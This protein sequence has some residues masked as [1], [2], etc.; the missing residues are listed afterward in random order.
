MKGLRHEA[1]RMGMPDQWSICVFLT[2]AAVFVHG[3]HPFA[4]DAGIY[5]PA[6]KK[7]LDPTLYPQGSEFFLLPAHW[8]V[9][10]HVLANTA[11]VTHLPLSY[12]LLIWYVACLFFTIVACWKIADICSGSWHSGFIGAS[13]TAVTISMPAAGCSLLLFDPYLTARSFSTPLLLFSIAFVLEHK[14]VAALFCWV[15]AL[16]FHPLMAVIGGLLL[17]LLV[18]SRTAKR[19]LYLAMLVAVGLASA[20]VLSRVM[21]GS[22]T[23]EYRSAVSTRSYFFLSEWKWYELVGA[24]APVAIFFWIA[25]R[26]RKNA[27][28]EKFGLSWAATVLGVVAILGAL[29]IMWIP[30]LFSLARFQPMRGFQL[31]YFLLLVLP[32]N[33]ALQHFTRTWNARPRELVF[34]AILVALG[35]AMYLAQRDTFPASR[36]IE[37]PWSTPRNSWQQAFDWIRTNTPKDAVFALDPDYPDDPGNDRQGFRAG[38]ERSALPDRAKDGGVAALFP[39]VAQKW[40]ASVQLTAAV[41]RL[42][43]DERNQL[44][45]AGVSW[46]LLR[47]E[48]TLRLDCPYSN[49]EVSVCRLI[50]APYSA[51]LKAVPAQS[52]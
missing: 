32:V 20:L 35:S 19:N 24:L 34:G 30:S 10:T 16:F 36:H 50:P 46:V 28:S 38:A 17:V 3:Y 7:L 23:G 49:R 40:K 22:V 18:V 41:S 13:L 2:L 26:H 43:D 33:A 52:P 12:T 29:A 9:F 15:A 21:D 31:I 25:F 5:I 44:L 39:Q 47:S 14:A 4:E 1:A 37:W 51:R 8:S 6:I 27:C 48:G 42:T 11:R 45:E